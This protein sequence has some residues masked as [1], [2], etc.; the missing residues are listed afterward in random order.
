MAKWQAP[1]TS[2]KAKVQ[3]GTQGVTTP[4]TE[5]DAPA[6][7]ATPERADG[8]YAVHRGGPQGPYASLR[9]AMIRSGIA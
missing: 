9:E 5:V 3:T 4:S 7:L 8:W 1:Y 6:T 2:S